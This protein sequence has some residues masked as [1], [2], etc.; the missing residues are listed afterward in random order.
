MSQ[1]ISINQLER[2]LQTITRMHGESREK[3]LQACTAITRDPTTANSIIRNFERALNDPKTLE[4]IPPGQIRTTYRY[5]MK[6]LQPKTKHTTRVIV[7][8]TPTTPVKKPPRMTPAQI[9]KGTKPSP[10]SMKP[11]Q[12]SP[13]ARTNREAKA[14]VAQR[15]KAYVPPL[16]SKLSHV[17]RFAERSIATDTQFRRRLRRASR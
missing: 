1:P 5:A 8:A 11:N 16:Y 2:A 4:K 3:I 10:Q 14:K 7:K 15:Q 6:A 12:S 13:F 9:A 17:M